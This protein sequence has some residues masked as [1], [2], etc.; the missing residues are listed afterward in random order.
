MSKQLHQ[1]TM[2]PIVWLAPNEKSPS[3][4]VA[5][6][7]ARDESGEVV[8]VLENR[9]AYGRPPFWEYT[10]SKSGKRSKRMFHSAEAT[11][12]AVRAELAVQ[13]AAASS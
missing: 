9:G 10:L 4:P 12:E 8:A 3:G 7:H 11:F 13:G 1:L 6:C 5:V 2:A